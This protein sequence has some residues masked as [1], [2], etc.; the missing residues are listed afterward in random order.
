MVAV[1]PKR[2]A[3]RN[4]KFQETNLKN[5]EGDISE[6]RDNMAPAHLRDLEKKARQDTS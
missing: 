1:E 5:L 2:Q 6:V 4:Y 3:L